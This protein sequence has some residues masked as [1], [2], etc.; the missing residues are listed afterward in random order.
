MGILRKICSRL[1]VAQFGHKCP[2]SQPVQAVQ[3]TWFKVSDI[4]YC[5]FCKAYTKRA[6]SRKVCGKYF[7]TELMWLKSNLATKI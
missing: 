5:H 7:P 4:G 2:I 6:I 3:G 1:F